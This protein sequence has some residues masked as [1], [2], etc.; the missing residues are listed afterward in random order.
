MSARVLYFLPLHNLYIL[1]RQSSMAIDSP[2]LLEIIPVLGLNLPATKNFTFS[3]L[4]YRNLF[5]GFKNLDI[6][7]IGMWS[8]NLKP[9]PCSWLFQLIILSMLQDQIKVCADGWSVK[10]HSSYY[11]HHNWTWLTQGTICKQIITNF[12]DQIINGCRERLNKG[13]ILSMTD[14]IA[15]ML[16]IR[17]GI[18]RTLYNVCVLAFGRHPL[19]LDHPCLWWDIICKLRPHDMNYS[20]STFPGVGMASPWPYNI[21]WSTSISAL[22]E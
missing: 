1:S 9:C 2:P 11:K 5:L 6:D 13:F 3:C 15:S 16:C 7:W 4:Y 17:S 10:Q 19:S 18:N 20:L 22:I 12:W 8:E 14:Q 21:F